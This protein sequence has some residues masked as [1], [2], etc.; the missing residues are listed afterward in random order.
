MIIRAKYNVVWF[1][2]PSGRGLRR[3]SARPY[4]ALDIVAEA[5]NAGLQHCIRWDADAFDLD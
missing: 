2:Y 4:T 5:Q 3:P 1:P